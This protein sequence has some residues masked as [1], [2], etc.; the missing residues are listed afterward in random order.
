MYTLAQPEPL[1]ATAKAGDGVEDNSTSVTDV[2]NRVPGGS[3]DAFQCG[4]SHVIL[5]TPYS[6]SRLS[7]NT[8]CYLY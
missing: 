1:L 2:R 4:G 8:L 3:L 6:D 5:A 7:H